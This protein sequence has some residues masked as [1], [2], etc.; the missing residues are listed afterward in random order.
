M[1]YH[2][3]FHPIPGRLFATILTK[4]MA[5]MG[6]IDLFFWAEGDHTADIKSWK[7][8]IYP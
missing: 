2:L 4:C 7:R 8:T 6:R 1:K 3:F 5:E